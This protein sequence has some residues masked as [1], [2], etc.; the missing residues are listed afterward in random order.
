MIP[1]NL[2]CVS[3]QDGS[4]PVR[5]LISVGEPAGIG[6]DLCVSLAAAEYPGVALTLLGDPDVLERRAHRLGL[7][8]SPRYLEGRGA[9]PLPGVIN[10][11]PI[12]FPVEVC[13]G[14]MAT[15][16]AGQLLE[17]L[18]LASRACL[19]GEYDALVTAPVHKGIIN[20]AGHRFTGHT[21]Y[22]A[23]MTG[24]TPVMMLT[25][26]GLRVALATTHI[27][28]A[29]VSAAIH[30]DGL[31]TVI[32]IL[33][34]DLRR[35]YRIPHPRIA[36]CGL[37]PHAGEG[38][39]LGDEEIRVIQPVIDRLAGEGMAIEG[40]FPADTIFV[41]DHMRHFD[42]VLAMYHDQGLPVLKH[43]GF[44]QAV[45]VTLGLPI[46][47]TSVDH[48][49]ALDKAGKGN[50]HAGS[51]HAAIAAALDQCGHGQK[52]AVA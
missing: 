45:N 49:T 18:A 4:S 1:Q 2:S 35:R 26:P 10:L 28:L 8:F 39:H 14:T 15:G 11:L 22:I 37:N 50:A 48:G 13:P 52:G 47:R 17:A 3:A 9:L 36:V 32:R 25:A 6:P 41:P 42:V 20:E 19:A 16:N 29:K 46:I 24:G 44:G 31:E 38:G 51:L 30:E 33:A 7:P 40:A 27:P 43:M 34:A 21:E 12:H 23:A 5:L